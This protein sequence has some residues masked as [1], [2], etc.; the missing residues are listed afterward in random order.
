MHL[1]LSEQG[2]DRMCPGASVAFQ[3]QEKVLIQDVRRQRLFVGGS[4]AMKNLSES[5]KQ[6]WFIHPVSLL[7]KEAFSR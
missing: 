1:I 3:E 7:V 2:H 5:S 6:W 4:S